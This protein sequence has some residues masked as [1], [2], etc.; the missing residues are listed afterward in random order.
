M[1]SRE[2]ILGKLKDKARPAEAVGAWESLRAFDD[3]AARFEQ[4]LAAV[5]GEVR[6]AADWEAA[7]DALQSFLAEI[8]A[9]RGVANGAAELGNMDLAAY[10]PGQTWRVAGAADFRA[11]C[12]T[13]DVGVSGAAAA[14]AETGTVIVQSGSE[15]SRLATLV[16]PVHVV[17]LP[18]SKLT[19]DLFTWTAARGGKLPANMTLISGPS[20]TADIGLT[21]AIGVHGPKRFVVI[22]YKD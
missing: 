10:L 5:A 7:L 2:K 21:L 13:A 17:L 18:E 16:P 1:N 15:Q 19:A 20:K 6:R 14:L 3:L 12:A 9:E 8:G 22:L 4:S 11:F